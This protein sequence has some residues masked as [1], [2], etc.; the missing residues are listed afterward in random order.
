MIFPK[1]Q[2]GDFFCPSLGQRAFALGQRDVEVLMVDACLFAAIW[3]GPPDLVSHG[4]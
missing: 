3:A 1:F 2:L 4:Q